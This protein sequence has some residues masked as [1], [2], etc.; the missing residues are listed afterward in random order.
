[1]M[2]NSRP[3]TV[4]PSEPAAT[5]TPLIRLTALCEVTQIRRGELAPADAHCYHLCLK[6]YPEEFGQ[7][8]PQYE[9]ERGK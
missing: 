9:Q 1:M 8:L 4:A 7:L 6:L 2:R 3:M 5:S